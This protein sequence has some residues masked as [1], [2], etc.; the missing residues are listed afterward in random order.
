MFTQMS[1]LLQRGLFLDTFVNSGHWQHGMFFS[2]LSSDIAASPF[3][4]DMA[5]MDDTQ[6]TPINPQKSSSRSDV[7][8]DHF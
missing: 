3:P 6:E 7:R 2:R 5:A 1:V 4:Q 8:S